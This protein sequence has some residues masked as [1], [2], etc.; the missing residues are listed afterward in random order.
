[1]KRFREQKK[2]TMDL[3]KVGGLNWSV[4]RS[5]MALQPYIPNATGIEHIYGFKKDAK[6]LKESNSVANVLE[7]KRSKFKRQ[8]LSQEIDTIF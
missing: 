8:F 4:H 3:K 1:M 6:A 7:I 5:Q 2:I